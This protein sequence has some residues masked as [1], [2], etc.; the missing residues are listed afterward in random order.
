MSAEDTV[1]ILDR[2]AREMKM[3]RELLAKV[4]YSMGEA[5]SEIPEKMRRFMMYMHDIHSVSY[6]YE[7]RG[8]PVPQHILREMERCDDRCR[9]LLKEQ[10]TDGGT[11]EKVRRQMA[12]D[13]DNRWDHTRLL[14]NGDKR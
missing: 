11:F 4:A 6:M 9:Q 12:S 5:E 13:P 10:H 3:V 1:A 8:L 2:I 14:T 7:E